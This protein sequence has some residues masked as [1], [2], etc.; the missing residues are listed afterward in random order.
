MYH[1]MMS[2]SG[3]F[4]A[5]VLRLTNVYGPR[6]ALDVV[7]QGFLSTFV[8]RMMLGKPLRV[9]GDGSQLRDPVYVDDVVEAFLIAG[10]AA[11][12]PSHS[13]N[14]G[15]KESSSL[16]KIAEIA[17]RIAGLEAPAVVPFP[18]DRKPIDIGSYQTDSRRIERELG[19]TSTVSLEEGMQKTYDFYR[20]ELPHYLENG[21]DQPACRMPEHSGV[22]HRL[23]YTA[24]P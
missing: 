1:L 4:D 12:L 11:K 14:V 5:A 21:A 2:R 13:Y 8:R 3:H 22:A 9:Y 23:K 18:S 19:W 17:S 20:S 6:M 16:R 10:I 7:C 24:V 15:S